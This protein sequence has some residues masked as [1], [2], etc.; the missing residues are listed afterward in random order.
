MTAG[1]HAA[2]ATSFTIGPRVFTLTFEANRTDNDEYKPF[3]DE[4]NLEC[5]ELFV[6]KFD[7]AFNVDEKDAFKRMP[8]EYVMLP[9]DMIRL[10]RYLAGGIERFA[11]ELDPYAIVGVPNDNQLA[12][13]YAR[14]SRRFCS[15]GRLLGMRDSAY[16]NRRVLV[17]HRT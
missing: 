9:G 13:W 17:I 1:C 10:S 2:W 3:C 5:D 6:V 7:H 16:H 15:A 4:Q 11:G 12:R 8:K 14:L